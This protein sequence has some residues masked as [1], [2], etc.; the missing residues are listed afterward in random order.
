MT[1]GKKMDRDFLF[2]LGDNRFRAKID[3]FLCRCL[4]IHAVGCRGH[5]D[6]REARRWGKG[7]TP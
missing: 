5:A 6:C 1:I 7:A 2:F 3:R 4:D